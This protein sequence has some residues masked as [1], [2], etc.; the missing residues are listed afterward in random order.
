MR[1]AAFVRCAEA[2]VEWLATFLVIAGYVAQ[3]VESK[4]FDLSTLSSGTQ[5]QSL[6]C[7][8]SSCEI[9][10]LGPSYK[11]LLCAADLLVELCML[12]WCKN[13]GKS[14]RAVVQNGVTWQI[15]QNWRQSIQKRSR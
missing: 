8:N 15:G 2:V 4:I 7:H 10:T 3:M 12:T 11:T 13:A 1:V 14:H 9:S 5:I 6:P